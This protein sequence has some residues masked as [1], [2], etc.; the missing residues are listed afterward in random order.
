M[1][2]DQEHEPPGE[3]S[4]GSLTYVCEIPSLI[5]ATRAV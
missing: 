2:V 5:E 1:G 3:L 4:E